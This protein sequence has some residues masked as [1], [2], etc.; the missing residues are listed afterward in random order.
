MT[1][2]IIADFPCGPAKGSVED[3]LNVWRGIP[4]ALPPSGDRRWRPPVPVPDRTE[5][6]DA[7]RFGKACP[8][9]HRR[10]GSVYECHIE[11]KDDDCLNLNIWAPEDAHDLPVFVWIHGGNLLRGAGSEALTDGAA[12]A[13]RGQVVVTINYRLNVHG[14]L[15]HPDLSAESQDGVSGNYGLLDQIAA[16]EWVQR[17]IAAAG[18]D[19]KNVTV[20][21]ES[22]GALSVYYLL[23]APAAKGLF[24]RAIAQSGH[25]CSAQHLGEDRYGMGT[26]HASGERLLKAL[27]VATIEE[28]RGWD[29]QELSLAA[30]AAGFAAQGVVDGVVLPDQPLL[31]LRDGRSH[32]VPLLAGWNARE[33]P[34]LEFLMPPVPDTSAEYE[35]IIRARY[36]DLADRFLTLYPADNPK[37]SGESAAGDAL[38]GWTVLAAAKAQ[39]TNGRPVHVYFF[40]HGY[41]EA[42]ARDLHAFHASELP[43]VFDTMRQ[44][45]PAWPKAPA[46]KE[47]AEMTRIIGAY[48]T[49][50][51]RDGTPAAH[52]APDWPGYA[53][54]GAILHFTDTA[55]V[56]H[57]LFPGVYELMDE[58]FAR[59]RA[60]GTMPWNWLVGTATPGPIPAAD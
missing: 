44:S 1:R 54:G 52:G 60:A 25:I 45:P 7:T 20:A 26:G 14:F 40:D 24:A 9:P 50:F 32:A 42:D 43:Y 51:T 30:D 29:P 59:R 23:C 31:M 5:M 27:G 48:W 38:F 35:S 15:A 13:R 18:G 22:A 36:G 34:T 41:P 10:K 58:D 55:E 4:Y 39:V 47:E 17:N 2:H 53:D 46:T 56:R 8:Q 21:G 49:S 57:D 28:L 3:G 37:R 33:I 19:P 11:D 6:F 16:L 12:L